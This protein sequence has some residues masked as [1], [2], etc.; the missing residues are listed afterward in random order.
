MTAHHVSD[1]MPLR[2]SGVARWRQVADQLRAA[3]DR[4]E[5]APGSR[6]PSEFELARRH[7]VNRHTVR[8]AIASLAAEGLLA[9]RQGAG[10]VVTAPGR[11]S[12]PIRRRTRLGE[13]LRDQTSEIRSRLLAAAVETASM[14]VEARLGL[15]RGASVLRLET[16]SEADGRP[17]SLATHWMEA[18]RFAGFDQ[19]FARTGSITLAFRAFG[20]DDY[21]RRETRILAGAADEVD[22]EHLDLPRGSILIVALGLNTTVS[23]A[24]LHLSRARF[25]ADRI[26]LRI[27]H[28]E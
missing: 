11:M 5:L 6:L 3:V 14:D 25:P 15:T 2:R 17:L 10:S 18:E 26:E 24:P 27:D 16:L 7:G 1:E 22:L 28:D 13:G 21:V 12:Y 19:A 20:I 4:G 8:A 9:T 23:G